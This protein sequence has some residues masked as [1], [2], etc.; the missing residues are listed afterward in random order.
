M[1]G[2]KKKGAFGYLKGAYHVVL[3]HFYHNTVLYREYTANHVQILSSQVM[4]RVRI[5]GCCKKKMKKKEGEKGLK[6]R[7]FANQHRCNSCMGDE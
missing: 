5:V 6:K 3:L 1:R 7:R 4:N 2:M